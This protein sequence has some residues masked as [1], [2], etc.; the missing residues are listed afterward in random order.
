M[1]DP[2]HRS[3]RSGFLRPLLCVLVATS[4][5]CNGSDA[6]GPS[7]TGTEVEILAAK[8][9]IPGG[10]TQTD[11]VTVDESDPRE[12]SQDTTLAVRVFGSGFEPGA[13]VRFLISGKATEKVVT[14]STTFV[15]SDEVVA[16]VSIALDADTVFYDI[17][18]ANGPRR[19][20]VGTEL[21]KVNEKETAT[22]RD[23]SGDGLTSDGLGIYTNEIDD[24]LIHITDEGQI[25]FRT[26]GTRIDGTPDSRK[27]SIL[28]RDASGAPLFDGLADHALQTR[29]L[30]EPGGVDVYSLEVGESR[31]VPVRIRWQEGTVTYTLRFGRDCVENVDIPEEM[32]RVTRVGS[33]PGRWIVENGPYGRLCTGDDRG[34][35]RPND[36]VSM[37][38]LGVTAPFG[39]TISDELDTSGL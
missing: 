16:D 17:E 26:D 29:R 3:P 9:G 39:V 22:L 11:D 7:V 37:E 34:T 10:P 31:D 28:V 30:S 33:H 15:S 14:H 32:G 18:V 21:F 4:L 13:E 24:V 2:S 12:A 19:R 8:G 25:Y 5:G 23:A 36:N 1:N 20:G 35:K 27:V 38:Y 6:T